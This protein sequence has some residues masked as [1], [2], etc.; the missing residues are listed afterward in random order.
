M[1]KQFEEYVQKHWPEIVPESKLR[2]EV[3]AVD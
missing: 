3:I 1:I 2:P